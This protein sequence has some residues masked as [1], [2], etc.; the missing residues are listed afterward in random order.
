MSLTKMLN[1]YEGGN[2]TGSTLGYSN[3]LMA[4]V[5]NKRVRS[6]YT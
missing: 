1:R 3:K 4:V 6:E 5:Q 2:C